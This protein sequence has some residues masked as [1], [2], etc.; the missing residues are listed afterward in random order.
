M[1]MYIYKINVNHD[2]QGT[3]I[4]AAKQAA[5]AEYSRA[6][7]LPVLKHHLLP[8]CYLASS[9]PAVRIIVVAIRTKGFSFVAEHV[10]RSRVQAV[11]DI[12]LVEFKT[13]IQMRIS[14]N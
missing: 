10:D 14:K 6:A 9:S 1:Y 11:F 2:L 3:R 7:G 12:T 13:W 5:S 4:S 8:R